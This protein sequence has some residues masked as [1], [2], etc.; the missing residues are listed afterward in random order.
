MSNDPQRHR[1][2]PLKWLLGIVVLVGVMISC[3]GLGIWMTGAHHR[4]TMPPNPLAGALTIIAGIFIGAVGAALYGI[5]IA[6]CGFIF[7]FQRP[8]TSR[9]GKQLWLLNLLVG[10]FLQTGIALVM[11][12]T[13]ITIFWRFVPGTVATLAAFFLPFVAAQILFIWLLIW[14]PLEPMT[15]VRRLRARGLPEESIRTGLPIGISDPNKNSLK[16]LTIVEED[17][18]MLWIEPPVL[19]YR[20]DE[21]DFDVTPALVISIEQRADAG[22]TS[23]YFGASQII[24]HYVEPNGTERRVR[25]HPEGQWTQTGKA[26]A[27]DALAER[28]R[29]WRQAAKSPVAAG[30]SAPLG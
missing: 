3:G 15:I 13:L 4:P 23:S 25:L 17:L 21:I 11:A 7:N 28:L 10:L 6:T 29:S 20:G 27:L 9:F 26:R 22:S 16:K 2:A 12:P 19:S 8:I 18:G 24:L 30:A 14:A 1:L 5:S